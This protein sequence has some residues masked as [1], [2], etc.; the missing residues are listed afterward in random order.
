MEEV[1]VVVLVGGTHIGVAEE[2]ACGEQRGVVVARDVLVRLHEVDPE[3][4]LQVVEALLHGADDDVDVLDARLAELPDEPLDEHLAAHAEQ[5]LGALERQ[6]DEPPAHAGGEDDRPTHAV[7]RQRGPTGLGDRDVAVPAGHEAPVEQLVHRLVRGAE[8]H[9][10][11]LRESA[12]G[13]LGRAGEGDEY[14]ELCLCE[15]G[16]SLVLVGGVGAVPRRARAPAR[17]ASSVRRVRA[18]RA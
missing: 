18:C 9:S 2:L 4:V 14:V 3:H 5:R 8:R 16:R 1:L 7:G 17:L 10:R 15:H 13:G 11:R 6:G 12:L